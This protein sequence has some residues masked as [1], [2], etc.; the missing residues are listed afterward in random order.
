MQSPIP[1]ATV[2]RLPRYLRFLEDLPSG[3]H[4][5]SSEEMA[6]G[7]GVK[8]AQVRKDL[9]RLG[10]LGTR[11]LGYPAAT[12]RSLIAR[13]LGLEGKLTLAIVGAGNLGSAL[14]NYDGF[15][16]RGFRLIAVYDIQESRIGRVLGGVE[17]RHVAELHALAGTGA[18]DIGIVATPETSA[19]EAVDLLVE[20]GV[21]SI[22][23][24]APTVVKAPPGVAIRQ[25]DV[26]TELQILS[27]HL[28]TRPPA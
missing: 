20:A 7:T 19:Q 3:Q 10:T 18:V 26:A 2:S 16:R 23:S 8:A 13:A 12:L 28:A 24:F 17:V 15:A 14:A 27:Y 21:G 9:S 5:V 25:V 1:R 6:A 4:T 22:L 11:G